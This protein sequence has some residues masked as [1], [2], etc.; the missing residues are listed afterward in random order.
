LIQELQTVAGEKRLE[1]D[2]Q[3]YQKYFM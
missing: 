1:I 2:Y 3:T